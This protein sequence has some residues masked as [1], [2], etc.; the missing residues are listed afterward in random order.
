ME[1]AY[2]EVVGYCCV[3]SSRDMVV[4]G[5]GVGNMDSR[6]AEVDNCC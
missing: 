5:R 3:G 4:T 2:Y 1:V 6:K